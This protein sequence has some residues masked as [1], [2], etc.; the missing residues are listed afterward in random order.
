MAAQQPDSAKATVL[1][2]GKWQWEPHLYCATK[3]VE[4]KQT[5]SDCTGTA[6]G[7]KQRPTP[8]PQ[9]QE[10][11][12]PAALPH[13]GPQ[14]WPRVSER[15]VWQELHTLPR[16]PAPNLMSVLP[17]I[18]RMIKSVASAQGDDE[19]ELGCSLSVLL[20]PQL[21]CF[22]LLLLPP[23]F[24]CVPVFLSG[25]GSSWKGLSYAWMAPCH[26]SQSIIRSTQGLRKASGQSPCLFP[27]DIPKQGN[28]L[29]P[30]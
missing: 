29:R 8:R 12:L 15:E 9:E 30:T 11:V 19:V 17:S 6:S 18:F 10:V 21:W 3:N 20:P 4:E 2:P 27:A 25:P 24:L 28:C 1:H 13:P 14:P 23:L 7:K 22:P 16:S 5:N 26:A